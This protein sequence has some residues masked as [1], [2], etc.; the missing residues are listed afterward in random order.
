MR[1]EIDGEVHAIHFVDGE[2]DAVER[3][4]TLAR[5]VTRQRL[6]RRE[7]H[8]QRTRVVRG[9]QDFGDSV[10]MTRH[11]VSA[12]AV[13]CAQR[14]LEVHARTDGLRAERGHAQRLARDVGRKTRR[15]ERRDRE[16]DA[17]DA[18]AVT[19]I[20]PVA[21]NVRE[22]HV[23]ATIFRGAGTRAGFDALE[24]ADFLND[25]GEHLTLIPWPSGAVAGG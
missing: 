16:A 14:R 7:V 20:E 23:D 11:P 13:A 19:E 1:Y 24:R 5:D 9:S 10:D 21:R 15:A 6:R 25:S 17:V 2:T 4:R 8:A 18:D 3:H 12:Q 22:R